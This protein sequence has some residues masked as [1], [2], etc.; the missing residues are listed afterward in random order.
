MKIREVTMGSSKPFVALSVAVVLGILGTASAA[1]AGGESKAVHAS[2]SAAV[3]PSNVSPLDA[4]A[5]Q[6]RDQGWDHGYQSSC[7][8]NPDCNGWNKKMDAYRRSLQH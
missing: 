2:A 4:L 3:A 5:V 8:V 6:H 7:D 1:V